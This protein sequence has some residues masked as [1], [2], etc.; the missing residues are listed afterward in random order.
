MIPLIQ[1]VCELLSQDPISA[2]QVAEAIGAVQQQGELGLPYEI[3]PNDG[4]W[5]SARIVVDSQGA[6]L[7]VELTAAPP[8][9]LSTL[10]ADYP[11]FHPLMSRNPDK[12]DQMLFNVD[13]PGTPRTC[14]I[15][16]QVVKQAGK[17]T[18]ENLMIRRDIRLA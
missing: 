14:A 9:A 4:A 2:H 10:Q 6:P 18:V 7:H 8:I 1:Q 3:I 5:S 16:A 13:I 12:L 15:I 17:S 11:D